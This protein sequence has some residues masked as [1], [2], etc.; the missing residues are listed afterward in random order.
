MFVSGFLIGFFFDGYRVLK[1]KMKLPSLLVFLIDLFFGIFSALLIFALLL[2]INHG[3]LR[4]TIIFAFLFSL[5]IYYRT[6]SQEMIRFWLIIYSFIYSL[7]KLIAKITHLIIIKPIIFLYKSI[8]VL[9]SFIISSLYGIYRFFKKSLT[10]PAAK[11]YQTTKKQ[12]RKIKTNIKKKAGFRS[13]LKKL[14]RWKKS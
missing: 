10:P 9:G 1:G 3:Q 13:L 6:T 7:W 11:L 4:F 14:F 12:G 8:L 2:W 5:W